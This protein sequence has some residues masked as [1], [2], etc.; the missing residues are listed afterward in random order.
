MK[1]IYFFLIY[2]NEAALGRPAL[3]KKYLLKKVQK[4]KFLY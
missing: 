3:E 2:I 1:N 4:T